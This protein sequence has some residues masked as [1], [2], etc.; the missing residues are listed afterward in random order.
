MCKKTIDACRTHDDFVGYGKKHGGR[1]VNGG[2]H[3]KVFGPTGGM[4]PVPH[5]PGDI[6]KGTRFSIIKMFIAI[7]LAC[8]VI[9]AIAI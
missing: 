5:H 4:A 6:A 8:L 9:V 1:V 2:R 3:T 7:G